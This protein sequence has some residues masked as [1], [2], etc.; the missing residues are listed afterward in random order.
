ML[1]APQSAHRLCRES[2]IAQQSSQH[3]TAHAPD[4]SLLYSPSSRQSSALQFHNGR[5]N[6]TVVASQPGYLGTMSPARGGETYL[7]H[8]AGARRSRAA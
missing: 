8:A 2:L 7:P 4:I 5:G 3:H 1:H 6:G